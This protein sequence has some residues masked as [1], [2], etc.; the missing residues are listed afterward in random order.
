VEVVLVIGGL[1][2]VGLGLKSQSKGRAAPVGGFEI[3]FFIKVRRL[4]L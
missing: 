3:Q 2:L 1:A 4:C